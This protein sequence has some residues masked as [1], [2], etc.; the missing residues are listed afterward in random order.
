[1]DSPDI[2]A[3]RRQNLDVI[4]TTF[5]LTQ[6]DLALHLSVNQSAVSHFITGRVPGTSMA[7]RIERAFGLPEGAMDL[8]GGA[9]Q[10]RLASA[11][12][13]QRSTPPTSVATPASPQAIDTQPLQLNLTFTNPMHYAALD[14]LAKLLGSG[15]VSDE[16]CAQ[17]LARFTLQR[18]GSARARDGDVDG[19]LARLKV[20]EVQVV[21]TGVGGH[22]EA[23]SRL[24]A[25]FDPA[26]SASLA[27]H[28]VAL[29]G[30]SDQTTH[31]FLDH[32]RNA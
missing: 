16:E 29:E 25:E 17:M 21:Y 26:L 32:L 2:H 12:L 13:P 3:I 31:E 28:V 18:A 5:K 8:E 7:R 11:S 10:A 9:A 27:R 30:L 24:N 6:W 14:A 22:A 15:R 1:M 19:L 20:N 4:R 23:V